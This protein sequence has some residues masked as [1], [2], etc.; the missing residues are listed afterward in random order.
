[1]GNYEI[2]LHDFLKKISLTYVI[3]KFY[4][5]TCNSSC[6]ILFFFSRGAGREDDEM[7]YN[8]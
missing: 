2:N 8:S 1:M 6:F 7:N 3:L 4:L 5:I